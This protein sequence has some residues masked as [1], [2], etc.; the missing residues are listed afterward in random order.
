M[1]PIRVGNYANGTLKLQKQPCLSRYSWTLTQKTWVQAKYILHSFGKLPSLICFPISIQGIIFMNFY[2]NI[3]G[4]N[5]EKYSD[6]H[7]HDF[8]LCDFAFLFISVELYPKITGHFVH[9]LF[10]FNGK[11]LCMSPL[12]WIQSLVT[13][14]VLLK[15]AAYQNAIN[16]SLSV[17]FYLVPLMYMFPLLLSYLFGR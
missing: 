16:V 12:L 11:L 9:D 6:P 5:L 17:V 7:L 8:S 2:E 3:K 10:M 15:K 14:S 13:C 4:I 1:C